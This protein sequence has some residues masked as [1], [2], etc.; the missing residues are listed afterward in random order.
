MAKKTIKE[1]DGA[2]TALTNE[3]KDL[4][5]LYD[6]LNEKYERLEKKNEESKTKCNVCDEVFSNKKHLMRH[7]KTQHETPGQS[8]CAECEKSFDQLWKLNA[9]KKVHEKYA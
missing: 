4:K 1:L 6:E 3:F 9:H 8:K 5:K 2:L 7:S